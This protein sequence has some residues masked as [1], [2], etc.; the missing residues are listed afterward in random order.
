MVDQS[1]RSATLCNI[2]QPHRSTLTPLEDSTASDNHNEDGVVQW[3]ATQHRDVQ[4]WRQQQQEE[5]IITLMNAIGSIK[6]TQEAVHQL[7]MR[8]R[9][10]QWQSFMQQQLEEQKA[11]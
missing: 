8:E 11:I 10:Q 3:I 9:E 6:R 7:W 2:D 5:M 1:H 4:A